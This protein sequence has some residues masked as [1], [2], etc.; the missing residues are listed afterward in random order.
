MNIQ[1]FRATDTDRILIKNLVPYYIY[2]MSEYMGWDCNVEGRW[3]G[4]AELPDYWEKPDHYPYVIQIDGSL[5]GF[6]L[7]RQFPGETERHEIGDFFIA[8]KFKG[9]GVGKISAFRVLD[10]H[11]GMWLVRILNGNSGAQAFWGKVID[12]YTKGSF[13]LTD[14]QFR[15]PSSGTWDMRFYRFNSRKPTD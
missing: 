15:D 5:A 14:E 12:E 1:L 11:P 3:D 6:V 13:V 10:A 2:D 9:H 8:R 4:C 7:V